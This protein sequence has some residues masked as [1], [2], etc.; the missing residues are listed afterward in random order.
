M[1]GILDL[2]TGGK[3][4]AA[5]DALSQGRADVK[6]VKV[7]T[8]EDLQLGPLSQYY[9][10]GALTPAIMQAAQAGPSAYDSENISGVPLS[11]MQQAL[12]QEG[13]I[14]SANGMTPQEQAQIAEALQ[15][16]NANTAGQR[17]AIQQSFAGM[18]VP[19]SL[20]SAALQNQSAGQNAQQGYMN[21][22][23]AQGQAANQGIT[24]LQNEGTLAGNMY[25]LQAGQQ[26][27]VSAAQNALNQFNAAN[28]QQ[29]G[30]ANQSNTQ[31]ANLY[32]TQTEQNAANQNVYGENQRQQQNQVLSKEQAAQLALEKSGQLVGVSEAQAKANT[33]AGEQNAGLVGGLIG[34]VGNVIT[35]AKGGEIPKSII[36]PT[37]FLRGGQ[38]PG[39]P[40]VAGDSPVNDTVPARLSPGEFVVPRTAMDKPGVRD[41][42]AKNVPTP[43]PPS[44]HPSDVASLLKALSMLRAGV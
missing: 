4:Q 10:T 32:N 17:G 37:A 39:Q 38:V 40:Q 8:A 21:A 12:A 42:L 1:G 34:K 5:Q 6:A 27:T 25:G 41:F 33:A 29:A 23:Q 30:L 31:A 3:N 19:Q 20:I 15:S 9:Q 26:N 44:A 36:P 24:A 28:T 16:V 22:L 7:P 43:R 14:A 18:G 2:I 35:L 13:Q 11:V